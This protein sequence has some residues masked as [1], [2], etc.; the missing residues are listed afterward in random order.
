ML[1]NKKGDFTDLKNII[2]VILII[3]IAIRVARR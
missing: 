1:Y 3:V 2:L